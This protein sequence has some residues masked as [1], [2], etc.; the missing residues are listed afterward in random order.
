MNVYN[1]HFVCRLDPYPPEVLATFKAL[2]DPTVYGTM[3]VV[4]PPFP[5]EAH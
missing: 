1:K 3:C 4:L 5:F 2:E